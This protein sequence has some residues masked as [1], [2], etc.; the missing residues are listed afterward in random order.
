M[1]RF[2]VLLLVSAFI[3]S[4]T[5][6]A[7]AANDGT[8]Q[9]PGKYADISELFEFWE[10]NGYP[11]YVGNVFS[12]DGTS[13]NLTV[14]LYDDDGSAEELIRSSLIDDT[15]VS[16]GKAEVS[17]SKLMAVYNE[18]CAN[19]MQSPGK[20]Y[21]VSIGWT[22]VDG[23]VTGF[24]ESGKESRVVVRVDESALKEYTDEF[25]SLYGD[26]VV[27][28]AG[29][30]LQHYSEDSGRQNVFSKYTLQIIMIFSIAVVCFGVLFLNRSR[31]I[32]ALQRADGGVAV[33]AAPLSSVETVAAIKNSAVAPS[34]GVL[35]AIIQ[36][37]GKNEE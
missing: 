9:T 4:V 29:A 25:Y 28:E 10:A 26:L 3:L 8:E 33:Q 11:G 30:P 13:Y 22:T 20:V 15:G 31:F 34:D 16:F 18:I 35:G 19:H 5:V 1:K 21:A 6:T 23:V 12:T 32:P 14:L 27:V 7:E 36:K 17:S 24:G 37:I 2:I